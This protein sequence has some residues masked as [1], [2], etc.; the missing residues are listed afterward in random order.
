MKLVVLTLALF[1]IVLTGQTQSIPR[2]SLYFV[3]LTNGT[4]LYSNKV[5]LI[6]SFSSGKY[7][8]L[9]SNKRIPLSQTREFKGWE[10]DFAVAR[11]GG[12]YD[13]FKLQNQGRKISLY[14]QCYYEPDTYYPSTTY[15]STNYISP[16]YTSTVPYQPGF[17]PTI[18]TSGKAFYFRKGPDGDM[19]RLNYRN[20]KDAVADDPASAR[21]ISI[22]G[23]DLSLGIGLLAGGAALVVAGIVQTSHRN[24]DAYNAYKTASANWYMQSQQNPNTPLPSTPPHYGPSALV[25]IGSVATL[26]AIIPLASLNGHVR[27]ALDIYNGID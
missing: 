15:P 4:T 23:V 21:E 26:S 6:T 18:R 17:S 22:A 12:E 25:Y 9:D 11:S 8:L 13:A 3:R 16:N 24:N 27:R 1:S 10:G 19:E 5:K 20:L 2:D 14:S 7:L